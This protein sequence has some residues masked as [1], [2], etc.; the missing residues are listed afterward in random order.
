MEDIKGPSVLDRAKDE[1]VAVTSTVHDALHSVKKETEEKA[2]KLKGGLRHLLHKGPQLYGKAKEE[3]K[4]HLLQKN[5]E[6][7]G[8]ISSPVEASIPVQVLGTK[9][10]GIGE[11]NGKTSQPME[12]SIPVQVL[13]TKK[14]GENNFVAFFARIFEKCCEPFNKKKD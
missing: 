14:E 7:N 3:I 2:E 12:T 10:E 9:Q 4:G 6:G 1:V 13:D 11:G 8:E 5:G